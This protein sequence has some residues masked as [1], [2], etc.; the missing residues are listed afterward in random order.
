MGDYA[1]SETLLRETI[2]VCKEV[3]GDEAYFTIKATNSLGRLYGR[4]GDFARA[5]EIM[6]ITLEKRR[7]T[8]RERPID[9][10]H[11]L[12]AFG[13]LLCAQG[14]FAKAAPVLRESLAIRKQYVGDHHLNYLE[15]LIALAAA[16]NHLGE[17]EPAELL[18]RECLDNFRKGIGEKHPVYVDALNG[19]ACLWWSQG[20]ADKAL[21]LFCQSFDIVHSNL[22][23]NAAI[24]SERQQLAMAASQRIYLDN[25]IAVGTQFDEAAASAY[26]AMLRWKGGVWMRQREARA[27]VDRPELLPVFKNIQSVAARLAKLAL[28]PPDAKNLATWRTQLEQLTQQKEELEQELARRSVAWREAKRDVTPEDLRN[29]LPEDVALIDF[30]EYRHWTPTPGNPA[31]E[32]TSEQHLLAVVVRRGQTPYLLD[33]GPVAPLSEAIKKWREAWGRSEPGRE[34]GQF[35]RERIWLPLEDKL[36]GVKFVLVSPDGVLGRLP[37]AALPGSKP[38]TYLLEEWSLATLPVPQALPALLKELSQ[39][40]PEEVKNLLLLGAVDYEAIGQQPRNTPNVKEKPFGRKAERGANWRMFQPLVGTE[41]ELASLERMYRRI[42]KNDRYTTLER[43]A[44]S[45]EHFVQEAPRHLYLHVA[46]HGFFAPPNLRSALQ[47]REDSRGPERLGIERGLSDNL[48][49]LVGYHPGLLSGLALAGANQLSGPDQED[50]ILTA[51]EVQTL[52]LRR[53]EL[54]VLSACET[55]LGEVAGGEGLLGLQRAFQVAG[56]RTTVASLWK[57]DDVHTRALMERVYSN[58]W[59]KDMSK[60]EALREAQLWMLREGHRGLVREQPQDTTENARVSPY[61]WAAFV[62]SGDWR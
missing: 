22:V 62:L 29:S 17:N 1:K 37:L 51:E 61:Y 19:L 36:V 8:A 33:L 34:A 11:E 56:A 14:E 10:A 9:Y 41:G 54:A 26:R 4:M 12:H 60:V 55:G 28:T 43:S 6:Q 48:P 45:K 53:V 20:D 47:P 15:T 16:L 44:A 49:R 31:P 2:K 5:N 42:F 3:L 23:L 25:L 38:G 40:G 46:T 39:S 59:E 27:V 58:L 35:L 32:G 21:P 7:R 18:Y 52:D 13:T 24:Q 50:G 57:V 30:L